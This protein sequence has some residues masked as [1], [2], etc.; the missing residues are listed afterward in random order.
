MLLSQAPVSRSQPLAVIA[1]VT[2]C[3]ATRPEM[4]AQRPIRDGGGAHPAGSSL[5]D[6]TAHGEPTREVTP[7]CQLSRPS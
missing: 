1:D 4:T 7:Q 3:V 2:I 5:F 6:A